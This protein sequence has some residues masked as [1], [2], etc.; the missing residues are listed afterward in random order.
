MKNLTNT[1]ISLL[2]ECK[3]YTGPKNP[4]K[5]DILKSLCT[6]KSFDNTFNSLLT[7]GYFERINTNDFSN[8]Y[9]MTE[10]Y[11]TYK[12]NKSIFN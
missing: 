7:L 2:N 5:Y 9:I 6:C 10:K 1:Q 4:V 3:K 8:Q 12:L 11:A